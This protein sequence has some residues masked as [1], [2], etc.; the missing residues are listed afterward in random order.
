MST[1][2]FANS[3]LAWADEYPFL[4]S[5]YRSGTWTV[6]GGSDGYNN[7]FSISEHK[8]ALSFVSS[9]WFSA[10]FNGVVISEVSGAPPIAS[11]TLVGTNVNGMDQSRITW[12]SNDVLINW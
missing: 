2:G 5:V 4:G 12:D 9:S 10:S 6:G 1:T 8:I 3:V 7:L 11:V